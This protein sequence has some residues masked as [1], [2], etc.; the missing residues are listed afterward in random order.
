MSTDSYQPNSYQLFSY[1]PISYWN[2][3]I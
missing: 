1:H 3:F 2:A